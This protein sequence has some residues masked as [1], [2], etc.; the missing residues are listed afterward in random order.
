MELEGAGDS[1]SGCTV[2]TIG[3]PRTWKTE[4]KEKISKKSNSK[5]SMSLAFLVTNIS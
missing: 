5:V 1:S 3:V 2:H 4:E